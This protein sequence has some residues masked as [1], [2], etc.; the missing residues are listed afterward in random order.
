MRSRS[1]GL[2]LSPSAL[3][4]PGLA[5]LDEGAGSAEVAAGDVM[6]ACAEAPQTTL[7]LALECFLLALQQGRPV[8]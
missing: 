2:A 5:S 1:R 8:S 7:N 3:P 6:G 4:P